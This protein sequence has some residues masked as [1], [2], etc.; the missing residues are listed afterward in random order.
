MTFS[1]WCMIAHCL[2]TLFWL[3]LREDPAWSR[4]TV[5]QKLDLFDLVDQLIEALAEAAAMRRLLVGPQAEEDMFTKSTRMM[6][7]MKD[8]WRAEIQALEQNTNPPV[9]GAGAD[10][11]AG[12]RRTNQAFVD[13][14][15]TG[16][17][18]MPVS[19]SLVDD[20]WLTDIFNVSW[21]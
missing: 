6:K 1:F 16:P 10:A 11:G 3:N 9:T 20:A 15:T 5:R 8:A 12:E 14:I 4:E 18:A 17:L 2:M 13:G 19:Q 7:A 21:E